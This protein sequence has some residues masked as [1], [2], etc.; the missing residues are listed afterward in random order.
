MF[1]ILYIF[2]FTKSW[3][4]VSGGIYTDDDYAYLGYVISL[5][6]DFDVDFSNHDLAMYVMIDPDTERMQVA[7]PMGTSILLIPFYII[8]KPIVL[9]IS[10][11]RGIP[12]NE[13]DPLF[14]VFLCSAMVM[15]F[16]LGGIFLRRALRFFFSGIAADLTTILSMWGTILP[17]YV[18]RRPIFTHVPE[19]FLISVLLYILARCYVERQ[20]GIKEIMVLGLI[21]ALNIIT[22]YGNINIVIFVVFAIYYLAKTKMPG[23]SRV[24]KNICIFEGVYFLTFFLVFILTQGL[25]WRSLFGGFFAMPIKWASSAQGEASVSGPILSMAGSGLSFVWFFFRNFIHILIGLDWGLLYTMPSF[26]V[27]IIIFIFVSPFKFF[28]KKIYQYLVN[29]LIVA[30][31]FAVILR[32]GCA[33][34]F[35]GYRYLLGLLPLSA[36][37]FAVILEKILPYWKKVVI[38]LS[39]LFCIINFMSILPFQVTE[40]TTLHVDNVSPLGHKGWGNNAYVINSVKFYFTND[41]KTLASAFLRGYLGVYGFGG[42][43]LTGVDLGKYSQKVKDYFSLNS[44]KKWIALL[45]PLFVFLFIFCMYGLLKKSRFYE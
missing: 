12:F 7:H 28:E 25:V 3:E 6:N 38:V 40:A 10:F 30:V 37:G 23:A 4:S 8:A 5:T 42:L 1:A 9:L 24:I 34:Q 31:P 45:Y 18:F 43:S 16:Y 17:V 27:G 20:V 41:K 2:F 19:F 33:G 21:S 44:Y 13:K 39:V 32:W 14:F 29:L 15:Y 22:R 36:F 26:L 11:F 35:Y